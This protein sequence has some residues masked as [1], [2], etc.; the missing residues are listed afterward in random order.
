[1]AAIDT[2]AFGK[3][4]KDFHFGLEGH[5]KA[6]AV[7]RDF[8]DAIES[9]HV[10]LQKVHVSGMAAADDFHNRSLIVRYVEKDVD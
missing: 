5:T 9:G 3:K 8:A 4:A 2:S 1:M 6:A 7:F 10:I